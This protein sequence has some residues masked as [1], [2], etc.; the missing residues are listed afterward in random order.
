MTASM[1]AATVNTADDGTSTG[2]RAFRAPRRPVVAGLG[3]TELGK[4]YGRT[5]AQFAADA[6]RLAAADAG[7]RL[8]QI[9][10]LLTSAG[11]TNGVNLSLQRDLGLTDLSLLAEMQAFGSTAAQMVQYASMAVAT[12]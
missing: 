8:S 3:I 1:A 4:V 6:V 11:V 12:G 9:D 5:A 2:P 7:L 10:G